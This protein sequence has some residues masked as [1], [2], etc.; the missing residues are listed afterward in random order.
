MKKALTLAASLALAS[1]SA[2]AQVTSINLNN[3]SNSPA[4][5]V[6]SIFKYPNAAPGIDAFVKVMGISQTSPVSPPQYDVVGIA[7]IDNPASVNG[8]FDQAFS[9]QFLL[10]KSRQP[11]FGRKALAAMDT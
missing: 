5:A 9:P 10:P 3:P 1:L 7:D 4:L 6:G 2:S 8:G 11:V